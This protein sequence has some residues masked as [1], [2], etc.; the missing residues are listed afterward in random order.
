MTEIRFLNCKVRA[1]KLVIERDDVARGLIELI[2]EFGITKLVMEAALDKRYSK[3]EIEIL[4]SIQFSSL[5]S[6]FI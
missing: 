6:L 4:I 1:E 2:A 3:Y 5:L